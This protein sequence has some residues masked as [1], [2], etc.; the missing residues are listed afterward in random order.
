MF[1][2]GSESDASKKA[3]CVYDAYIDAKKKYPSL[4]V[5]AIPVG[6]K[7][8]IL[9]INVTEEIYRNTV[10]MHYLIKDGDDDFFVGIDLVN[11]EDA[12]RS[13]S[14]FDNLI[15]KTLANAPRLNLA[16]HAG[17]STSSYNNEIKKAINLGTKRIGHGLNL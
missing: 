8:K 13:I 16:L 1:L 17:E 10:K 7:S 6:L 4:T 9:D 14:E 15:K 5:R 12:S 11:E 3:H 2:K